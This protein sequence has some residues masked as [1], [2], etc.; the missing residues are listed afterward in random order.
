[1]AEIQAFLPR[2]RLIDLIQWPEDLGARTAEESGC[3]SE[4]ERSLRRLSSPA[5][6]L[7]VA[8][9]R[10][11]DVPQAAPRWAAPRSAIWEY[12]VDESFI[13]SAKIGGK[14]G[15]EAPGKAY[16]AIAVEAKAKGFGQ[17]RL[18]VVEKDRL[19]ASR[20]VHAPQLQPRLGRHQR[21]LAVLPT[22]LRVRGKPLNIKRSGLPAHDLFAWGR[23]S[24]EPS[25]AQRRCSLPGL[26]QRRNLDFD[27]R[28]SQQPIRNPRSRLDKQLI[29][30][31]NG[32]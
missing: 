25:R 28:R 9:A 15:R 30:I 21:R 31:Q 16:V 23:M 8:P 14:G 20:G 7:G 18:Q 12:R 19:R 1:M 10:M 6:G 13:S 24:G 27:F 5:A 29:S 3:G 2:N 32:E 22:R 17:C 26:R 11:G 4:G